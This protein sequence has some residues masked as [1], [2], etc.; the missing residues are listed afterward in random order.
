MDRLQIDGASIEYQVYGSGEPVLLI[1]PGG[2]IDG[3]A[4]PML[5][6]PEIASRYQLIHY[7]RRGYMGSSLG[8][9][10]LTISTA[11]GDVEALLKYLNVESV[12]VVGHSIG[13]TIAL[14]LA[15]NAPGLVHSLALLEPF[16]P[17][18]PAGRAL[19]EQRLFP[20]IAA[21]RSGNKREAMDIFG[22]TIFGP[23]WEACID[24]TVPG[25]VEQIF[26][27]LDTFFMEMPAIM[28]WQV[29]GTQFSVVRQ[30][31]LSV[32]GIQ[33]SPFMREGRKVLHA[34]LPQTEDFDPPTTHLLQIQDPQGVAH[35]LADF[36]GRHPM[37]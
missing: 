9:E 8:S 1:P 31:V 26:H 2:V 17:A 6:Q 14:Q 20:I 12:H 37:S 10:P 11:T 13:G 15:I 21:Y 36:F 24:K 16:V 33:S 22:E 19:M 25:G 27:D 18:G 30:P 32:L 3:L 23:E 4:I 34:W 5:S 7:H 28:A 35:A 29:D